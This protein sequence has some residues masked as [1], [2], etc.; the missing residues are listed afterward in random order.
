MGSAHSRAEVENWTIERVAELVG[1]F[2]EAYKRYEQLIRENDVN[3]SMLLGL[4]IGDIDG[5]GIE[6]GFHK[7]KFRS[8]LS[9]LLSSASAYSEAIGTSLEAGTVLAGNFELEK[10]LGSGGMG[11]VW[12][13]RDRT[14]HRQVAIK[15]AKSAGSVEN[16]R[17]L[18]QRMKQEV[19]AVA[20]CTHPNIMAIH[21]ACL[22]EEEPVKFIVCEHLGDISLQTLLSDRSPRLSPHNLLVVA[23]QLLQALSHMH[24]KNWIHR[25]MKPSNVMWSQAEKGS[26]KVVLI[27]FGIAKNRS[28]QSNVMPTTTGGFPGTLAYMGPL[29]RSGMLDVRSD[30][31]ALAITIAQCLMGEVEGEAH[32][33][34]LLANAVA[35][36]PPT[37]EQL[38]RKSEGVAND[39]ELQ[40]RV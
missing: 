6:N 34:E 14:L 22:G 31:W 40:V 8:E 3:G 26:F 11:L 2:G 21:N 12:R 13:A 36:M 33:L 37:Q 15:F 7:A 20:Q 35:G 16:D 39:E 29:A 30:L 17:R 28:E 18:E 5:L 23:E 27:D 10:E 38:Q 32:A 25:D 4:E 1:D 19:K 9:M 24:S